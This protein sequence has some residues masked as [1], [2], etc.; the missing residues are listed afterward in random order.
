MKPTK[1]RAMNKEYSET[2]FM[3]LMVAAVSG[4][5]AFFCVLFSRGVL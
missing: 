5:T 3:V 2:T 4:W 1:E